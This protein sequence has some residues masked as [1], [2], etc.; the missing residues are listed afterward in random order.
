MIGADDRASQIISLPGSSPR[1]I[2][3]LA[4]QIRTDA[5]IASDLYCLIAI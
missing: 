5:F 4:G 3:D 1:Q 2:Q